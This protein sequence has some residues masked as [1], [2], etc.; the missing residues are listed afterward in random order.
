MLIVKDLKALG[1]VWNIEIVDSTLS[2]N[3]LDS[4]V[5]LIKETIF[6]FENK[7][8]RFNSESLLNKYNRNEIKLTDSEYSELSNIL[9]LAETFKVKSLGIFDIQVKNIL[10]EIGY[11]VKDNKE[12]S[13]INRN[14]DLGGIGKGYLIDKIKNLLLDLGYKYFLI[15]GGGD[16]Y[17]TSD[18]GNDFVLFLEYPGDVNKYLG[19]VKIQNKSLCVSSSF[20]RTWSQ[21]GE[22]KNHFINPLDTNELI[23]AASYVIADTATEADVLAT[24]CCIKSR[25]EDYIKQMNQFFK[26]DYLILNQEGQVLKSSQFNML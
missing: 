18:N 3:I 8:S 24:I 11:G 21:K 16:I 1:T 20:K 26:F 4:H 14:I 13:I 2:R 22:I 6:E 5:G 9:K 12:E 19:S 15:N 23:T 10:E 7:Y 25:D 17:V